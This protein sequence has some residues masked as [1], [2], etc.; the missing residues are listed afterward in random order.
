MKV[1]LQ[2]YLLK[3]DLQPKV[4]NFMLNWKTSLIEEELKLVSTKKNLGE[5]YSALI[6]LYRIGQKWK[7]N[8]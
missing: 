3:A 1:I 2:I 8:L 7:K 4:D 5:L 6:Y